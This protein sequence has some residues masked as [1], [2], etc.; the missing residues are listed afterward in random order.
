MLAGLTTATE[1]ALIWLEADTVLRRKRG[2]TKSLDDFCKIFH[3]APGGAPVVKPY[4]F[5]DVVKALN[6]VVPYDWSGFWTERLTN[7]G[8]GA[9]LGGIEQTG[10][11]LTYDET[12]TDYYRSDEREDAQV[13]EV[14]T[15]VEQVAPSAVSVLVTGESGTGKELIARAIHARSPRRD[16][17]RAAAV[18]RHAGHGLRLGQG[19]DQEG[20]G[21]HSAHGAAEHAGARER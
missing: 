8:P 2:G 3:G 20:E 10:W 18:L 13:R 15:V 19:G 14:Y 1:G 16:P 21:R 5:E 6:Q 9:P 4:T 11:K 7:H 12:P 17:S